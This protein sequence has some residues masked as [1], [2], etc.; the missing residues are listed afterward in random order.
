MLNSERIE[1]SLNRESKLNNSGKYITSSIVKKTSGA[2]I[3]FYLLIGFEFL[4]MASPFAAFFYSVY[5]PGI[6]FIDK[7]PSIA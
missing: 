5:R 3:L 2:A 4:Y 7:Y 1:S 6:E